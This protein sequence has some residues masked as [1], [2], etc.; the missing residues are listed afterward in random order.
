VKR[1]VINT[2]ATSV[3]DIE[4]AGFAEE[5]VTWL[6]QQ[7]RTH[8]LKYLLAHAEDGVIWGRLDG[9]ELITS[10]TVAPE[11]SPPLRVVTLQ[12]VRL[13]APAGELFVWRDESGTWR[14]R[15]ITEATLSGH[16]SEWT[17]AFDEQQILWGTNAVQRERGFSL[18]SEGSQGLFHVVPLHLTESIGEQRRPLRLVVRHYL[19]VDDSGFVRVN[20]SRLRNLLPEP[21]ESNI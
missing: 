17:T 10:H 3:D 1:K 4:M 21:K 16:M 11:Y 5:P 15:L 9:E 6:S 8:T 13:F 2:S 12:M 14:S 19:K 20:A 7:M 18:M